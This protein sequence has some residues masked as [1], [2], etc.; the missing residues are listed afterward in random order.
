MA[1]AAVR[2]IQSE[3]VMANAKHYVTCDQDT[4]RSAMSANVDERSP[5]AR[6]EHASS[7]DPLASP[8]HAAACP[9][10]ADR[11][12]D[13]SPLAG[14]TRMEMYAPAFLG[15]AAAGA[16]SV[17]CSYSKRRLTSCQPSLQS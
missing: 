11:H 7:F 15:A 2:G 6:A 1:A 9:A 10:R 4:Q 17:M 14:S 8:V 3:G 5:K 12:A 16:A 13:S